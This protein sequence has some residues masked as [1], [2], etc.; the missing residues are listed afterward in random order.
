[1][2]SAKI[3]ARVDRD[4]AS[5]LINGLEQ[6]EDNATLYN[7]G[8][9]SAYQGVSIQLRRL[10]GRG[11]QGL[12]ARVLPNARLHEFRPSNVPQGH[13][14]EFSLPDDER[15]QDVDLVDVRGRL[16]LSTSS[17]GMSVLIEFVDEPRLAVEAWI[18]QW[19][20]RPDVKVGRLIKDVANEE[21]AHTQAEFGRTI[22]R[23][24]NWSFSGAADGRKL[25]HAVI[26]ALG[27]YIAARCR[28]ILSG[29][30][31][32]ENQEAQR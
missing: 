6:I 16:Q 7:D 13:L 32:A 15:T 14:D 20:I 3:E 1:M 4:L 31:G 17:P 28:E 29:D 2:S 8:R 30:L 26:V 25:R 23:T 18:E 10:L 22:R 5:E 24:M 19:I 12:L 9:N 11:R 21:V 27:S